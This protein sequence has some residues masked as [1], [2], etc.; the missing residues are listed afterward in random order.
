MS[1]NAENRLKIL[2]LPA[3]YPE[4]P[5]DVRGIFIH[6]Q[7]TAAGLYNEVVVLPVKKASYKEVYSGFTVSLSGKKAEERII[8]IKYTSSRFSGVTFLRYLFSSM[9]QI[10]QIIKNG[11]IPDIIHAHIFSAGVPAVLTAIG[12]RIPVIISEHSSQFLKDDLTWRDRLKARIAFNRADLILPVS[13]HLESAIRS[14]G[15]GTAYKILPNSFDPEIFYPP[16]EP[17][18][19]KNNMILFVG[20]LRPGKGVFVLLRS[21]SLLL[22]K[23]RD[24]RLVVAGDGPLRPEAE[25][26]AKKLNLAESVV[27]R[28]LQSRQK[29]SELMREC[30]FLVQPSLLE[31]FS[32]TSIEAMACGKP[33]VASD[34]PVFREK[35]NSK[36]GI[37]VPPEDPAA[38]TEALDGMLD[39]YQNYR[40][41]R[42]AAYARQNFSREKIARRLVDIYHEV[43][44][45]DKNRCSPAVSEIIPLSGPERKD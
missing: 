18:S 35:I 1:M 37:L 16:M 36:R 28:G 19:S 43:L 8:P 2:F 41:E 20:L 25:L 39:A 33:I 38:L 10:K 6:D 29:V 26:E 34:L 23:R 31:T 15:W 21:L 32:V 40:S 24:F 17:E 9:K 4:Y 5:G 14:W 3:W 22:K 27:F 45:Q 11:W 13:D 30:S 44:N 42:I 7:V 12:R